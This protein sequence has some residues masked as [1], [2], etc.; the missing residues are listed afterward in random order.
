MFSQGQNVFIGYAPNHRCQA[1]ARHCRLKAGTIVDGPH[2]GL[3]VRSPA[4][5][6]ATEG[7]ICL[8]HEALLTPFQ[9]PDTE[10]ATTDSKS[11]AA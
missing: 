3:G 8:V 9:D 5:R 2:S 1:N 6:V 7:D 10:T 11:V 4:W